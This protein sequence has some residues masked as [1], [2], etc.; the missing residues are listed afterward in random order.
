MEK[1]E[2]FHSYFLNFIDELQNPCLS[3]RL[4]KDKKR[5]LV[6]SGISQE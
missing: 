1:F 6:E 3:K 4:R 5:K 2:E